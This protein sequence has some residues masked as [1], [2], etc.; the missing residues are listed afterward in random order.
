[1]QV[2]ADAQGPASRIDTALQSLPIQNPEE[3][4]KLEEVVPHP[5]PK[6]PRDHI[7]LLIQ[8]MVALTAMDCHC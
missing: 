8:G 6:D 2:V 7:V 4:H 5:Q 1:M 3:Q